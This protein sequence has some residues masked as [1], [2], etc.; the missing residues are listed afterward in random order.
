VRIDEH[1]VQ[2]AMRTQLKRYVQRQVAKQQFLCQVSG[3]AQASAMLLSMKLLHMDIL[4]G[5]KS[6]RDPE[7]PTALRSPNSPATA[8]KTPER[9]ENGKFLGDY[10]PSIEKEPQNRSL[11][12]YHMAT[13]FE[14][15]KKNGSEHF[16]ERM[17]RIMT[18]LCESVSDLQ[19]E[20]DTTSKRL[21]T[22]RKQVGEIGRLQ[23]TGSKSSGFEMREQNARSAVQ[24][25]NMC[26]LN[27]RPNGTVHLFSDII[28]E[29]S[30]A[31]V[32]ANLNGSA[33]PAKTATHKHEHSVFF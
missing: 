11:N 30:P 17:E 16:Q 18:S 5:S 7:D 6:S 24:K 20:L 28:L 12:H 27:G 10:D 32:K 19:R 33:F 23:N 9:G 26:V 14:G 21:E 25:G 31:P 8:Y 15:I 29:M 13:D 2:A 4:S 22:T 3:Q 1:L